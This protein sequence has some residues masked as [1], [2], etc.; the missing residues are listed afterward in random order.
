MIIERFSFQVLKL[1]KITETIFPMEITLYL[2]QVQLKESKKK[3]ITQQTEELQVHLQKKLSKT[4][5]V[6]YVLTT[7]E[8][9]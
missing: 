7:G 6:A 8:Q 2:L 5:S 1:H 3:E 4:K 9:N